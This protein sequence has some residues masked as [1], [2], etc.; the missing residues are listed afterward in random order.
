MAFYYFNESNGLIVSAIL[1]KDGVNDARYIEDGLSE[2]EISGDIDPDCSIKRVV[3]G[4]LV[5]AQDKLDEKVAI[6]VR[7]E[8]DKKLE[9]EVDQI[10]NNALRWASLTAEQQQA[11]ADYRQA[12]LDVPSQSGFPHDIVW[13]NKPE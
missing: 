9:N 2:I 11:L 7:T 1:E 4:A 8:R 12:L 3:N 6:A 13:P 10:S 5:Y